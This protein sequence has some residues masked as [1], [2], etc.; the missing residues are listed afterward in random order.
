M[1]IG[2]SDGD[3]HED[4]H[5][6]AIS[7]AENRP[8][9]LITK[10]SAKDNME[11][12]PDSM[13]LTTQDKNVV[14]PSE[15]PPPIDS[16]MPPGA[17]TEVTGAL[18]SESGTPT[19]EKVDLSNPD[20]NQEVAEDKV[21]FHTASPLVNITQGDIDT[22][23]NIA[24]SAGAGTMVGIKSATAASRLADLGHAQVLNKQGVPL[25]DIWKK[26]GWMQ[27]A[28]GRW[29]YEVDDSKA[30]LSSK[31]TDAV[32]SN[33]NGTTSGKLDQVIDHPE[34]FKA[35]PELRSVKVV[36]DPRYPA[37]GAEWNSWAGPHGAITLSTDAAQSTGT[38]MHEVQHVIQDIEG[39]GKG[40]GPGKAGKDYNLRL[41]KAIQ[42]ITDELQEYYKMAKERVLNSTQMLRYEHLMFL[43]NKF[44]QY[45]KA[46]NREAYEYYLRLAGETEAR[47]VDTRLLM[48]EKA[49]RNVPPTETQDYPFE[50][51][52][53][54][55]DPV[56]TSAYGI[57]NPRTGRIMKSE[58]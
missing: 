28:E 1:P 43:V 46:G 38:M 33:F 16:T 51:Q 41:S 49:R 48:S 34:L 42:P 14:S 50:H 17:S 21:L 30:V 15:I 53:V 36:H 3:F 8:R 56:T 11:T 7:T 26:T 52:L 5:A 58:K 13:D 19:P 12:T 47:N 37:G 6:F 27:G 4:E 39:F 54:V 10:P 22:G 9:I 45:A 29:R 31:W 35:Y 18:K 40:G 44:Q 2:T 24:M 25:E 57:R 20:R 55:D 32:K 23:I